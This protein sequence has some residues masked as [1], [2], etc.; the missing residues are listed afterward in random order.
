LD[1]DIHDPWADPEE[2]K[3]EYDLDIKTKLNGG[4]YQAIIIAVAH[5]EFRSI[6]FNAIQ[7]AVDALVF[8]TKGFLD[9]GIVDGRL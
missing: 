5:N 2:V 9:R 1:V 8:D 4:N 6:D 3:H 7:A